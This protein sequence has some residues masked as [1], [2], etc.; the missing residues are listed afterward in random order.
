MYLNKLDLHNITYGI[1]P[2]GLFTLLEPTLGII[3]ACLPVIR[4][5]IIKLS[6]KS[7]VPA[8]SSEY[9]GSKAGR[10]TP[11]RHSSHGQN[12]GFAP[13]RFQRLDDHSYP[14]TDTYRNFQDVG[15][16][17]NDA[18]SG[19]QDVEEEVYVSGSGDQKDAVV[20]S[21]KSGWPIHDNVV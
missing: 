17:E 19:D 12:S 11:A 10:S 21:T 8:P 5:V 15:G 18:C 14:L 6:R 7:T 20:V 4:P 3:S 9:Y 16:P 2:E 1:A 13:K